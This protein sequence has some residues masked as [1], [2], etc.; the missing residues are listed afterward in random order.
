[1]KKFNDLVDEWLGYMQ[2]QV[3]QSTYACYARLIS[4]HIEPY[5]SNMKISEINQSVLTQF[6]SSK[7]ENGRIDG[8]GGLS[9]KTVKDIVSIL[10]STLKYA[11]IVYDVKKPVFLKWRYTNLNK[12]VEV[13]TEREQG[14]LEEYLTENMDLPKF[15]V[16]IC[17]YSG[18]RLGE[19]CALH[20]ED[21]DLAQGIFH[22]R[23][24]MQ[25]IYLPDNPKHTKMVIDLP[26]TQAS[27]RDIP[28]ASV[29]YE[30]LYSY[31]RQVDDPGNY[32]ISGRGDKFIDPRTYQAKF[33]LYLENS[34]LRYRNFHSLRHTFATRCI[35]KGMDV[36][37]LSEILGHSNVTVTLNRYVHSSMELK[38]SQLEKLC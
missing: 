25:R 3:K 16:L 26:K 13:L 23:R 30:P 36:K 10:N 17:L 28:I 35:E 9:E 27:I 5:F 24:A 18:M 15:G 34:G 7:L 33:K 37:S 20:W 29:L 38:R 12:P 1:M 32:F 8:R 2:M 31:Y 6:I 21:I 14:I 11:E 19:I 4:T 22:I